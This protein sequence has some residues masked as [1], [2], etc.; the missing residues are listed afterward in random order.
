MTKATVN[1]H[2][3]LMW[4]LSFQPSWVNTQGI[5]LLDYGKSVSFFKI[6]SPTVFQ[7]GWIILYSHQ[8]WELLLLSTHE[9]LVLLQCFDGWPL[10]GYIG[11]LNVVLICISHEHIT[12]T[13]YISSLTRYLHSDLWPIIQPGLLV[14]LLLS[15]KSSSYIL[16]II[17]YQLW[18]L[19]TLSPNLWL[20][21]LFSW[22]CFFFF[23]A[24]F[25]FNESSL[26]TLSCYLCL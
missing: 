3:A 12:F 13:I 8:R 26:S 19:Q 2:I 10:N 14:F 4:N 18:F 20:V 9:H 22:L 23:R 6:L 25:N 17:F 5:W 7:S 1:I 24:E 11:W 21:F 16:Y 15:F